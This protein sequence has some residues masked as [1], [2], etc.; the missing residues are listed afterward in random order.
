LE[1]S[2]AQNSRDHALKAITELATTLAIAQE[3]GT[4]REFEDLRR[5]VAN[6]IGL[7]ETELLCRICAEHPD[8][9]DLK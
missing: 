1:K 2:H 7:I 3:H 9:D 6:L 8:L 4:P 5:P